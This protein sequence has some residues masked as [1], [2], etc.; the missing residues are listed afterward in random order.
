MPRG[1][2]RVR[3]KKMFENWSEPLQRKARIGQKRNVTQRG[4]KEEGASGRE[5]TGEWWPAEDPLGADQGGLG[6][7]KISITKEL[8]EGS[9]VRVKEPGEAVS[10]R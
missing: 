2:A 8:S 9:R 1:C 3:G 7:S 4:G 6:P 5:R 10:R